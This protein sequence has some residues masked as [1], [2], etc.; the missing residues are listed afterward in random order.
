[1][2]NTSDDVGLSAPATPAPTGNRLPARAFYTHSGA[3]LGIGIL[4]VVVAWA[5]VTLS[6][7]LFELAKV[8]VCKAFLYLANYPNL[9][10]RETLYSIWHY[11]SRSWLPA[12]LVLATWGMSN[13]LSAQSF[14]KVSRLEASGATPSVDELKALDKEFKRKMTV[15]EYFDEVSSYGGSTFTTISA[16]WFVVAFFNGLYQVFGTDVENFDWFYIQE[17]GYSMAITLATV[18]VWVLYREG[19]DGETPFE[20]RDDVALPPEFVQAVRQF[21]RPCLHQSPFQRP[22]HVFAEGL[23]FQYL[24]YMVKLAHHAG[25]LEQLYPGAGHEE[26][27]RLESLRKE[28]AEALDP[29]IKEANHE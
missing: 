15:L 20:P 9:W 5:L 26:K 17:F 13:V 2:S 11:L 6:P 23:Q 22:G 21:G 7:W 25:H 27:Q 18:Y 29:S 1:M 12:V 16:A 3:K 19:I 14:A 4:G 28:V 8:Y 24:A 10:T